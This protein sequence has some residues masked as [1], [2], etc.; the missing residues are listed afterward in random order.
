[1]GWLLSHGLVLVY[2]PS[3]DVLE[4]AGLYTIQKYI[5]V[6]RQTIAEHT[7]NQ[8]I[9][10]LYEEVERRRGSMPHQYWWEQSFDLDVARDASAATVAA[11]DE[12]DEEDSTASRDQ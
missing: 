9:F 5:E 10:L 7:A 1:M 12:E 6:R 8:P 2:P 4:E 11:N 3:V